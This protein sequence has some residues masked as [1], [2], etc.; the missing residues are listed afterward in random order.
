MPSRSVL[1][2]G[3]FASAWGAAAGAC[4]AL[5][6]H[7]RAAGWRV[8]TTSTKRPRFGRLLDMLLTVWSRRQEYQ[9]ACVDVYSG[10]AFVWAA[11]VCTLVFMLRKPY[12]LVLH[13]GGLPVFAQ[14]WGWLLDALAKRSRAIVAQTGYLAAAVPRYQEKTWLIPN[15]LDLG[16]Y[17]FRLRESPAPQLIWLRSFHQIYNPS[18]AVETFSLLVSAFPGASL[19]MIGPDKG[20]GSLAGAQALAAARGVGDRVRFVPG[21]P[22]ARVPSWLDRADIFLNTTNYDNMPVSVAEAMACGLCVVSTDVGGLPYL[23]D[24]EKTALLVPA[25]DA[26]AM[27]GAVRRVILDSSLAVRLST[28]GRQKAESLDWSRVLPLWQELLLRVGSDDVG[29]GG[30]R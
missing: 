18:M 16:L 17:R 15:G 3:N 6:T 25:R 24:D 28:L 4:E 8:T 29:R 2:V 21:I 27:A 12:L 13:G 10:L 23:L 19:T 14:R 30:R 20:D 1:V 5:A 9:V 7:L 11:A 22:K 26:D